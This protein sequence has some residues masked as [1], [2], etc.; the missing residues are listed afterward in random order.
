MP[1]MLYC[2]D[3]AHLT[4]AMKIIAEL[5][6]PDVEL[7]FAKNSEEAITALANQGS[8][9]FIIADF[10]YRHKGWREEPRFVQANCLSLL[11]YMKQAG[12][13]TPVIIQSGQIK[14]F[15]HA[16]LQAQGFELPQEL[17]FERDTL[18]TDIV[19]Y[20]IGCFCPTASNGKP[21]PKPEKPEP[22]F[23]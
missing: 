3:D 7:V 16:V 19:Q 14:S 21:S 11:R 12:I 18:M 23:F 8:F 6:F 10:G 5:E 1:K 2:E 15:M 9:D 4:D 22:S 17:I 20:A 13:T